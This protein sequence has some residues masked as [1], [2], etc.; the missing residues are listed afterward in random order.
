VEC[1]VEPDL[2]IYER[3]IGT[4]IETT[5]RLL[6]SGFGTQFPFERIRTRWEARYDT[7]VHA[8]GIPAKA[9]AAGLLALLAERATPVALATSSR[10]VDALAK[11]E[12]A[13]LAAHFD[14]LVCGGETARGKPDPEPYLR[15]TALLGVAPADAWAC[16]DSDNGTRAAVAAGLI[17]FQ[18]PD[19]LP[20]GI[21]GSGH[22]VVTSLDDVVA[23]LA[24]IAKKR[25]H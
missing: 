21:G 15:A 13:G 4:T 1:G 18:V 11:L 6:R 12:S 14:V 16:E 24:R 23:A 17:V 25:T 2:D 20:S 3:C 22:R 5:E 19:L 9:G 8:R 7:V 10:R